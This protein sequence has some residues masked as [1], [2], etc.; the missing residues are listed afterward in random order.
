MSTPR[1][2]LEKLAVHYHLHKEEMV[3]GT[4]AQHRSDLYFEYDANFM[5]REHWLS[6]FR[7]PLQ[8]GL[9]TFQDWHYGDIW[10]LFA[11]S[12]PDGWGMLLMDRFFQSQGRF[13]Q[14]ITA[15]ERLAYLGNHT[16]G[17]LTY[18]PATSEE[19]VSEDVDLYQLAQESNRVLSGDTE[20]I[21]P[22]LLWLG[23]SPG[24]ARPKVLVG[25]KE[26]QVIS[27]VHDVPQGY[28]PYLLKFHA[29]ADE[30]EEGLVEESY[31]Q[32][33]RLAGLEVPHTR[34]LFEPKSE[35]YYFAIRRFDRQEGRRIHTHTLG[36]LLHSSHRNFECDYHNL[37]QVARVLS[38]KQSC[39]E[40]AF[41][42]MI[43]NIVMNNRDD[44]VKNFSFL[45]DGHEWY[46][47]P[48]YDLT[49]HNGPRGE[50]S[51]M[52]SKE[53]RTPGIQEL[54]HLAKQHNIDK[55]TLSSMCTQVLEASSTWRR[56]AKELGISHKT[57][58]RIQQVLDTNRS[59]F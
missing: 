32:V 53:G 36:G 17:A 52:V 58:L 25:I 50:H 48:S 21:L 24:G 55:K 14:S 4:L 49:F 10:G 28:A 23:G 13:R 54:K 46:Y 8:A 40:K 27:G 35:R 18:H 38:K 1:R 57:I 2:G 59:Y 56:I 12:L 31:A 15:L 26:N 39:V 47:A 42:Q 11:D 5:K 22:Q 44:H 45:Y 7:L 20:E 19:H 37:L 29:R 3:V 33:A 34:L 51:M 6:P 41:R 43:F 9:Q 30:R 16:M